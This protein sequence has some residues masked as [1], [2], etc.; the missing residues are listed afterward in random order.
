MEEA[1]GSQGHNPGTG[2][3]ETPGI[4]AGL[5]DFESFM[6]MLDGGNPVTPRLGQAKKFTDQFGF[7]TVGKAHNCYCFQ[8]QRPRR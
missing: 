1:W 5:V 2:L 7:A 4:F 3:P 8:R 6:T